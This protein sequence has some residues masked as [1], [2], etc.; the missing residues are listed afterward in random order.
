M[1]NESLPGDFDVEINENLP[2]GSGAK[3]NEAIHEDMA[4]GLVGDY[5]GDAATTAPIIV[6]WDK[7][8]V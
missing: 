2:R 6:N 5:T 7:Q 4:E 3:I 1:A 8:Q